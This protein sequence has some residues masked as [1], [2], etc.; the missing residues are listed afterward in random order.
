VTV[1][2]ARDDKQVVAGV[3]DFLHL[4]SQDVY[5]GL[6]RNITLTGQ[7]S[8]GSNMPASSPASASLTIAGEAPGA[9]TF[10]DAIMRSG[11]LPV[12]EVGDKLHALQLEFLLLLTPP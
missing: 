5:I 2:Y 12:F 4:G 9:G 10:I 11:L 3:L 6:E 1:N 7:G 8:Y